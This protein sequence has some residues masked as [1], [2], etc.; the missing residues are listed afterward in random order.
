MKKIGEFFSVTLMAVGLVIFGLFGAALILSFPV[1][2]FWN[3]TIVDIF[4]V[5]E[6]G[7]WKAFGLYV[8]TGILFNRVPIGKK[9]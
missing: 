4:Q 9:D 5:P 7:Y 1:M 8:I 2:W 3:W 6:I